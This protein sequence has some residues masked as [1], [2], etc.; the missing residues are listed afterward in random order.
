MKSLSGTDAA[1]AGLIVAD[2]PQ[3]GFTGRVFC[4]FELLLLAG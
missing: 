4:L 2:I 1:D 3:A